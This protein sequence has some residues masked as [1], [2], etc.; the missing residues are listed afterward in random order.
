MRASTED[1]AVPPVSTT[2]QSRVTELETELARVYE[3]LQEAE[4]H[5]VQAEAGIRDEVVHEIQVREAFL[6]LGCTWMVA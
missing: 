3:Q 5:L 4:A 6:Y 1:T 2:T